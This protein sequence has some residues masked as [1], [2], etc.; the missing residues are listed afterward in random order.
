M[1][2]RIMEQLITDGYF[3][4]EGLIAEPQ[5]AQLRDALDE[6]AAAERAKDAI[7]SGEP[8][9]LSG[10][11]TRFGGQFIRHLFDRHPLFLD[12]VKFAPTLSVAREALGPQVRARMSA[13]ISF[14]SHEYQ[15]TEW[16]V[17]TA[18]PPNPMPPFYPFP[19][20]LDVLIYLDAVNEANGLLYVLPGSHQRFDIDI[21]ARDFDDKP[22]QVAVALPPG[23]AV[24][25]HNHLWHRATP[26][27]PQGTIR[28]ML[29]LTYYPAWS[30]GNLGDGPQPENGETQKLIASGDPEMLELLGLR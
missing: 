30:K 27:T 18:P 5:L 4:H 22:G 6:V 28:R 3:V 19:H 11:P 9:P 16:H 24:F 2:Q 26:T 1:E 15:Q 21:P 17:H 7:I 14:P 23:S 8:A 29:A 10:E 12:F 20:S 25:L 13:R